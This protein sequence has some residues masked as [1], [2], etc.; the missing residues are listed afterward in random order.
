MQPTSGRSTSNRWPAHRWYLEVHHHCPGVPCLIV[1]TQVDLRYEESI[2]EKL[3]KPGMQ[4]VTKAEGEK[5]AR[6]LGAV[7]YVESSALSQYNLKEVFDVLASFKLDCS[8]TQSLAKELL[9]CLREDF[10]HDPS[11][12]KKYPL[13]CPIQCTVETHFLTTQ[14]RELC[15]R[16]HDLRSRAF[17]HL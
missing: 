17:E 14:E 3:V 11:R 8:L 6:E 7:E 10:G 2:Q 12:A 13:K 9:S 4:L 15:T 5:I 16:H 1:D